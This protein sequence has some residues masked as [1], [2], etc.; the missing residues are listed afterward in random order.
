VKED[1]MSKEKKNFEEAIS[2]LEY[3]VDRLERGELSL[4]ES[5]EAFQK[6]VELSRYCSKKLDEAEK[7]ITVLIENE[8][9][10][11]KKNQLIFRR[12]RMD[13]ESKYSSYLNKINKFLEENLHS[14]DAPEKPSMML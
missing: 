4:E 10:E 5:M 8:K 9:G 14:W 12:Y 6:G 1:I 7:K 13:F 11:I 2:E 3:I